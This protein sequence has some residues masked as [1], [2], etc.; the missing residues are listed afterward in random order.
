MGLIDFNCSIN[1]VL[2]YVSDVID[3]GNFHSP[4]SAGVDIIPVTADSGSSFSSDLFIA[5]MV[6]HLCSVYFPNS[7]KKE[8][9]FQ[10]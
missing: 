9:I 10:S 6:D 2:C 1:S 4:V 3:D 5:A 8:K 7:T